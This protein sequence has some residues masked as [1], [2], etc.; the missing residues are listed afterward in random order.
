MLG[1]GRV[2]CDIMTRRS[3]AEYI[4]PWVLS[5]KTKDGGEGE[6]KGA[7]DRHGRDAAPQSAVEPVIAGLRK[8]GALCQAVACSCTSAG[9]LTASSCAWIFTA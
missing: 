1:A 2:P 4:K 9:V 3:L 5:I 6:E 7:Q 8:S